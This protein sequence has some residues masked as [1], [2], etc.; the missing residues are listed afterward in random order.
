M[1]V[2]MFSRFPS[3]I[4]H[5]RGGVETATIGLARG[6]MAS[7]GI[8]L[9]MVTF[10]KGHSEITTEVQ[11]D[12][13]IHRL[14]GNNVPMFIDILAGPGKKKL[15]QY[16]LSLKPDIV[17]FQETYG[18]GMG[19]MGIPSLFTVHGFD[20]LNLVTEQS[21]LWWIRSK[22]WKQVEKI[23][24]K[25]QKQI[26]SI[27]PYVRK[28]IGKYTNAEIHDI[29]NAISESYFHTNRD[30]VKGRVFFAGWL[31]PRKNLVGLLKAL[32]AVL[33]KTDDI[34][35]R[36]AGEAC[37]P[38]YYKQIEAV[39][40]KH[41]LSGCVTLLGRI[42]QEA[43]KRELTQ[44]SVFVLP[45]KQENAPMAIAEAMAVGVPVISSNVCGMPYMIK[46]EETG[47]LVDPD[48]T[49]GFSDRIL[50]LLGDEELYARM[51]SAAQSEALS[52][53]HPQSVANRTI[54]VY[55]A[56]INSYYRVSPS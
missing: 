12:I 14:P 13:T 19:D 47:F 23:G 1:K 53:Y 11:E 2:V 25:K 35:V 41:D 10:E 34:S 46:D 6:L 39:I 15:R 56:L 45:S 42:D 40:N 48:D 4:N 55:K 22:L 54:A 37:D 16:I 52:K 26:I 36:V 43:I 32:P 7:S 28:E 18:L 9:H 38:D 24:L 29:E 20:S 21:R 3:D 5:P 33:S 8:D 17:H 27:I 30:R 51:S 31:N 50:R 49:D 44:A